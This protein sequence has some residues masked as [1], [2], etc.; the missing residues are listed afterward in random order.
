MKHHLCVF[1]TAVQDCGIKRTLLYQAKLKPSHPDTG[2]DCCRY[3][4]I[5]VLSV[6]RKYSCIETAA[7]SEYCCIELILKRTATAVGKN[8]IDVFSVSREYSRC[9]ET[10]GS[11]E[12]CCIESML[13][14]SPSDTGSD[15]CSAAGTRLYLVN[16]LYQAN[17]NIETHAILAESGQVQRLLY[18]TIPQANIWSLPIQQGTAYAV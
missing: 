13:N 2:N 12:Y 5:D 16:M 18:D 3:N 9:I 7:S 11:S 4:T 14:L 10:A 1:D 6:L 17:T 8:T 15:Y